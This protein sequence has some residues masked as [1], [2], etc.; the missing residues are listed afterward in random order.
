[1]HQKLKSCFS[2][3][4]TGVMI[5]ATQ[6]EEKLYGM[7]I[8]SFTSV[9]LEPPLLLFSIENKSSNLRPFKKSNYFSLSVLSCE[10]ISIAKKFAESKNCKKW[11][12]EEYFLGNFKNPVFKNSLGFFECEKYNVIKA[13][14][15]LIMI[16]KIVD[17]EILSTE[18]PLFYINGKFSK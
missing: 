10:Q 4:P 7:T 12:S 18:K 11:N 5:A 16:G 3:F 9:S 1:V 2:I 13:G 15:H 14:D 6:L 17:F 8:N